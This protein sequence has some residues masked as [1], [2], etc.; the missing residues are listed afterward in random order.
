MNKLLQKTLRDEIKEN[1]CVLG[2]KQVL[3]AMA[4]LKLVVLSRSVPTSSMIR[5]EEAAKAHEVRTL[6]FAGTSMALGRLC[7]RQFRVS[8]VSFNSLAENNITSIINESE[9]E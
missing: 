8:T 5:L 4:D 6:K 3:G 1:R 2:A 9:E 7:G